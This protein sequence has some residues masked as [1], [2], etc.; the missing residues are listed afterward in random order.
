MSGLKITAYD[1]PG[2]ADFADAM[3]VMEKAFDSRFGEAWTVQQLR[4][5][6]AMPGSVLVIGRIDDRPVGFGLLRAIVGE[7]ELLLLAVD[8]SHRGLG[9]GRRILDRCLMVA[10]RS[11]AESVF[12]EVRDSNPA[13]HLYSKAGFS[14]YNRRKDYYLGSA[15]C[16]YD[17][18]SFK[19]VLVRN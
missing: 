6:M 12:L 7:A 1:E 11:G 17:A 14:Q 15:G 3:T 9:Y 4:S 19:A 10:E 5:M 13:V 18:L 8:P 2:E 16:R